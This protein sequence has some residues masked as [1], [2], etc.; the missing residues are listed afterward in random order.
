MTSVAT[1]CLVSFVIN[2]VNKDL[3][4][5]WAKFKC[6]NSALARRSVPKKTGTKNSIREPNWEMSQDHTKSA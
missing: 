6:G 1:R 3:C 2:A 5:F 4:V